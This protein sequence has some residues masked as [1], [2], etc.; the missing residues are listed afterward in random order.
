MVEIKIK[1]LSVNDA[2]KGR[3]FRTPEYKQYCKDL[4]F[5][6][7]Q[8]KLPKP[9]FEIYLE[10]GFSSRGSDTG[11]PEKPTVD[12]IAKKYGFNDN[13]IYKEV[14]VKKIVPKGSEYIKFEIRHMKVE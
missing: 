6:L 13:L 9:P 2:W 11:N 7:P 10:W 14:L 3:R 12:I 1:P 8:I 5:L 4:G